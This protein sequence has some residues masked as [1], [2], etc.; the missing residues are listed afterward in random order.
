M[1]GFFVKLYKLRLKIVFRGEANDAIRDRAIFEDEDGRDGADLIL[2]GDL[3]VVIHVHFADLHG[4]A[5]FFREFFQDRGDRFAGAAPRCPE[6][7][8]DRS[9]AAGYRG[10]KIRAIEFCDLIGHNVCIC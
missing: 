2:A 8:D 6:I 4:V 7:N 9:G 3:A 5:E 1:R 10:I